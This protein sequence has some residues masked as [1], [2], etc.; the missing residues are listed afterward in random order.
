MGDR[1]REK[2]SD[3]T[4]N[5]TAEA[6]KSDYVCTEICKRYYGVFYPDPETSGDQ[7][8]YRPGYD[9]T[10]DNPI[11]KNIWAIPYNNFSNAKSSYTDDFMTV[12]GLYA[13]HSCT[14]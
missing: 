13:N 2:D 7:L 11:R 8:A 10:S 9:S 6:L 5:S 12:D 14:C 3:L 4:W 1:A